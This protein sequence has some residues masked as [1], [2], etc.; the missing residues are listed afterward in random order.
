MKMQSFKFKVTGVS[1][2][3]MNNPVAIT[4][5]DPEKDKKFKTKVDHGTPQQQA[6]KV[7]YRDAKG[8]LYLPSIQFRQSLL[9]ACIGKTVPKGK[10][11]MKRVIAASVFTTSDKTTL[12]DP[13]TMKPLKTWEVNTMPAV[14]GDARIP[15]SRPMLEKWAAIVEFDIDVAL[16]DEGTV[17]VLLNEAG[18]LSGVG[19]YRPSCTGPFGRYTAELV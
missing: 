8:D 19:D 13:Q 9:Y 18:T 12:L 5:T 7:E 14:V 4:S 6:K 15:R 10:S 3:L 17:G 2:L 1:P 11:G 16:A